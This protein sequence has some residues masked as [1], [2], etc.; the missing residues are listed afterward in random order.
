[1]G[2]ERDATN[3][4]SRMSLVPDAKSVRTVVQKEGLVLL[5][6]RKG[7]FFRAND[8]G[9]LIWERLSAGVSLER[10]TQEIADE[11]QIPPEMVAADV[12]QFID[13]LLREGFLTP[14]GGSDDAARV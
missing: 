9:A 8:V 1:M 5:H 10:I 2:F 14:T 6:I 11:F 13:S 3:D 12:R 7:M 4:L